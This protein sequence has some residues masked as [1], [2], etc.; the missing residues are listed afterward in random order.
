MIDKEYLKN[1]AEHRKELQ[2]ELQ[3]YEVEHGYS[4]YGKSP[5]NIDGMPHGNG[6]KRS[7]YDNVE[8]VIDNGAYIE[9]LEKII[10][11]ERLKIEEL[12]RLLEKA[13]QKSVIRYRY[14][15][16]LEWDEIAFYMYGNKRDYCD[17]Y[18]H[19]KQKAQ[20]VHGTAIANMIS[21][22]RKEE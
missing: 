17:K 18:E 7:V 5:S 1:H 20:K 19:Y 16:C 8:N 15:N 22:Q 4:Y 6:N 11:D 3:R 12:L 21:L 9:K 14:Y 2:D 10:D 13:N